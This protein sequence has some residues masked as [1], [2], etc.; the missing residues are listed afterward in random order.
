[1][2]KTTLSHPTVGTLGNL[3]PDEDAKLRQAWAHL[4]RLCGTDSPADSTSKMSPSQTNGHTDGNAT[5]V[6]S[7]HAAFRDSLW[8][9]ILG[10]H[11]DAL[12]LR[13]LRARK[14]DIDAAVQMLVAAARWRDEIKLN[15]SIIFDGE[16][17][18]LRPEPSALDREF[19]TQWRLGKSYVSGTDREGRLVYVVR[20]RLHDPSKQSAAAMERYILHSIESLRLVSRPPQDQA[21]LVFD[22]TGFGLGNMDFHVVKFIVQVF[23]ARYPETLGLVL[24]HN[25]PFVFWGTLLRLCFSL[26]GTLLTWLLGI[27]SI[28]KRWLDPNVASKVA[29]TNGKSGLSRYIAEDKLL[30]EYG[31]KVTTK[32]EYAEPVAGENDRLRMDEKRAELQSQWWE[33]IERFEELTREWVAGGEAGKAEEREALVRELQACYWRLDPYVRARTHYHRTGAA[34]GL[35]G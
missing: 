16:D 26:F 17:V 33:L 31:G 7:E 35:G 22:L 13:F 21:C 1:M 4:L 10:D 12:A 9:F 6:T 34:D 14:W 3:M 8:Q 15:E 29:F 28:V 24:V 19:I 18:I 25:A 30:K 11:P 20:V 2:A 23:E 27:W 32:Y 5:P